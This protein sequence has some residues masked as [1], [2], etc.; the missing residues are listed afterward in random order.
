MMI[1]KNV[2]N[3]WYARDTS[4]KIKAVFNAKGKSGKPLTTIL[5]YGYKKSDTDKNVWIVDEETAD[6]VRKVFQL[7]ID[8]YG[9]TQIARIVITS[10]SIHYTKLYEAVSSSTIQTFLSV[11]DFL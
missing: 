11:S 2:F 4:K 3:D 9:P 1:F 5:P 10:Y 6:V 8:G 7:C